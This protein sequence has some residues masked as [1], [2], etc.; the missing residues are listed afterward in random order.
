[1]RGLIIVAATALLAGGCNTKEKTATATATASDSKKI[2]SA[3]AIDT[4]DFKANIEVPGLEFSGKHMDINGIKLYPGSSIRGMHVAATDKGDDKRHSVA[5]DFISP[6]APL[7]VVEYLTKQAE[8]A[9]YS[10][11]RAPDSDGAK[12]IEG[13]RTKDDETSRLRFVLKPSG[14]QTAGSA[15]LDGSDG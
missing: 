8:D 10:V 12:V 4:D 2:V 11:V 9:G 3:L 13:T 1:M 15:A 7:E 6:A 5:F 14:A